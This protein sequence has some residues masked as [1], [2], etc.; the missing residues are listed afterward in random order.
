MKFSVNSYT[1]LPL[2]MN[3]VQGQWSVQQYAK[4]GKEGGMVQGWWLK[5]KIV[6][7]GWRLVQKFVKENKKDV[8][9]RQGFR[10]STT[11]CKR[12]KAKKTVCLH[13]SIFQKEEHYVFIGLCSQGKWCSHKSTT[14]ADYCAR[15]HNVCPLC[16]L[17]G[18]FV[19]VPL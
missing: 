2:L 11:S 13:W 15:V 9:G 12:R 7:R 1:Q 17:A 3:A 14:C 5:I 19:P 16:R 18:T 10:I 8:W 6:V 4:K